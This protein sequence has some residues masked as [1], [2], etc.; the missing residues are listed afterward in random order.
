M[1]IPTIWRNPGNRNDPH[2]YEWLQKQTDA[3]V[4]MQDVYPDVPRSEKYPLDEILAMLSNPPEH[5]LTSSVPQ[6]L[7]LAALWGYKRIEVYGVAMETNTEYQFQREGVAFWL[8]FCRGRGIDIYFADP[9]FTA[10]LYGY[11]GKVSVDYEEFPRRI[12]ELQPQIDELS[13]VHAAALLEVKKALE[14]FI[15]NSG[16]DEENALIA[17]IGRQVQ[18]GSQLGEL[19][20]ARQE[21]KRYQGKADAMKDANEG[22]FIFSR[23]EF[24]TNAASLKQKMENENI[25]FISAGTQLG[26][27]H[28][29]I[30]K[31]AKGSPKRKQAAEAFSRVLQQYLQLNNRVSVYKGAAQENFRY[32]SYLDQYIRAAGGEKSEAV[33]LE[34]MKV[35]NV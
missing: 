24:E 11:E 14:L 4:M 6:A 22:D 25:A 15:A 3:T 1:H 2:H 32:M 26:N 13:K 5:F 34:S 9:T 17:C 27:V 10:P 28:Q 29:A 31:A 30:M 21:N 20:G 12:A 35:V 33:I 19:D 7:A 18:I 8:G 16:K 23:Q